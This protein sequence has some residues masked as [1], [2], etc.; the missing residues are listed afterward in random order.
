MASVRNSALI[1]ITFGEDVT[2]PAGI[3]FPANDGV[4]F[5]ADGRYIDKFATAFV[6]D[7]GL[8]G[9]P[10]QAYFGGEA[11]WPGG[12]LTPGAPYF[13]STVSPGGIMTNNVWPFQQ[14]VGYALTEDVFLMT[15]TAFVAPIP[16]GGTAGQVVTKNSSDDYDYG[17]ATPSGG[18]GGGV[19]TVTGPGV[20]NTDA[21]N[22]VVNARPY[23]V[24]TALLTQSGTDAPVATVME[25]T[26]GGTVVWSYA[27]VGQ[28]VGTLTGAFPAG[29][30]FIQT[31]SGGLDSNASIGGGGD[32]YYQYRTSDDTIFVLTTD[33]SLIDAAVKIEVYP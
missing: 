13:L 12:G 28:Y 29:K 6:L 8:T 1:N 4:A 10:G 7:D 11:D 21:A 27:G 15:P 24:Y 16:A 2:A 22:P 33:G 18:G 19:A 26:L 30:C 25:N 9:D 5:R 23:K 32:P 17:W 14:F 20:D 3:Y 31:P